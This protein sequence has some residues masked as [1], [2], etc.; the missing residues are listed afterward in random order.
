MSM[1]LIMVE[2]GLDDHSQIFWGYIL[3][4]EMRWQIKRISPTSS[5]V[6]ITMT[7]PNTVFSCFHRFSAF[8]LSVFLSPNCCTA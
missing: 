5:P 7:F 1:I 3:I 4:S 6:A 8:F 2:D